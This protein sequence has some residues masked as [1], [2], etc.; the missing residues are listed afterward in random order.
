MFRSGIR[1]NVDAF[2]FLVRGIISAFLKVLLLQRL[3]QHQRSATE[4]SPAVPNKKV[5]IVT[6]MTPENRAHFESEKEAIH[7][8][9]TGIGDEIYSTVDAC[10]TG[11]EMWETIER[12]QQ[13]W[14]RFI[15][16]VKQQDLDTVSYHK[17]FDIL[18]QYQKE[19][20]ELRAERMA[21]NANPLALVATAHTLQDPYYQ[22]SKPQQ[23]YAPTSISFS[24]I[25]NLMQN[26]KIKGKEIAK[27]SHHI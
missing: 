23:S 22:T 9:L 26:Y 25:Q 6:N 5:E 14:L 15:T 3:S 24:S 11:Q 12:L 19:V 13:E 7:L 10:Q 2:F 18:K 8:I 1:T 20:N 17:L 21:K 4:D 27:P 16:I